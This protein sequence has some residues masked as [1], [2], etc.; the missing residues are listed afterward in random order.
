MKYLSICMKCQNP[1]KKKKK[2][3][4]TQKKFILICRLLKTYS[5]NHGPAEP[6]YVVPL[7]IV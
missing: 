5:V 1:L 6:G 7:Q 2:E 3:K 4:E